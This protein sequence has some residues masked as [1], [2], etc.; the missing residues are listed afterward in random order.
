MS[1]PAASPFP[2][3]GE[4]T[5]SADPTDGDGAYASGGW[6]EADDDRTAETL[7]WLKRKRKAHR[8]QQGR[9]L[10]LLLY[11]LLLAVV[12]YGSGLAVHFLRGLDEG[13]D[14]G[15]F[16]AGLTR[17][18]PAVFPAL[19]LLLCLVSARDALWRGPVV[20]P[21]PAV[22]WLLGQ[23]VRRAA[24]LRPWFRLSAGLALIPGVLGGIAGAVLLRV[25]GQASIGSALPAVL[26][27]ALCLPL[28][29][30]ALGMAV[31]R[32]PDRAATVRRWTAPAVLLLAA[33]GAQTGLAGTGHRVRPLEWVELWS[34]P[35]GWAAQPVVRACGG[36]APGWPAA[37]VLLLAATAAAVLLAHRE[38]GAVPTAQL[39][40]RAATATTVASVLWSLELRAAKLALL[41]AAGGDATRM[42]RLPPPRG[43]AARHLAVVWR[44]TLTLL[45]APGRLGRSVLWTAAAATAAGL[46][47]DLGGERRPVGLVVG[48][49]CGYLAVG[50]LAES[51]RVETDDLRRSAW[52]PYRLRGLMLQHGVVPAVVGAA[53]GLLAAVPLALHGSPA[54][55]LDMPLCAFPFTA[56]AL[57]GACRGPART[58]LMFLGGGSPIGSPGPLIY[59]AWYAAGPLVAVTVL[60][61]TLS[62]GAPATVVTV[63]V[64]LTALIASVAARS[65]TKLLT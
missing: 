17:G 32:R 52:S 15:G 20:L 18:L 19:T 54:A 61:L 46:G 4:P 60:A 6:S 49:V 59:L 12:G 37:V 48:L 28:L 62:Y 22:G 58:Q 14:Y 9:D 43:R 27:A 10:A 34:G 50:A 5:D 2:A 30:V 26:P 16:G 55:L 36:S 57:Y 25:T 7:A 13:A 35:W 65:A 63:S 44:D 40:A 45:R 33:L 42:V 47:A 51:A 11:S 39:R 1:R 29:A 56:A 64:L 38:A 53:L 3:A 8:R 24:V 31:E 21:G 41:D 23:P